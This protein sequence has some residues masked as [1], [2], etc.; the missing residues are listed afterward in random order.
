MCNHYVGENPKASEAMKK[1]VDEKLQAT[2]KLVQ[3]GEAASLLPVQ[4]RKQ[5]G[6]F[7]PAL[8]I[9]ERRDKF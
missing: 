7:I 4:V 8:S 2:L 9:A 6:I 3:G 1:L 5:Q